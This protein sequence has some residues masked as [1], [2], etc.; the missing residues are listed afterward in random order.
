[1]EIGGVRFTR[2]GQ[3]HN[4]RNGD[5]FLKIGPTNVTLSASLARR[6]PDN[7]EVGLSEDGSALGISGSRNPTHSIN[8]KHP[9]KSLTT[10]GGLRRALLAAGWTEGVRH[11]VTVTNEGV[12]VRNASIPARRRRA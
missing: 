11:P 5:D 6:L 7:V 12:I 8:R 9:N 2:F 4:S 3:E 1:M 10:S